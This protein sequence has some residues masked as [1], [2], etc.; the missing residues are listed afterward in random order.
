M[1]ACKK[2]G[3][4][5]DLF[6]QL[7]PWSYVTGQ[8]TQKKRFCNKNRNMTRGHIWRFLSIGGGGESIYY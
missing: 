5:E 7:T 6:G 4:R 1:A 2:A 3:L 8:L